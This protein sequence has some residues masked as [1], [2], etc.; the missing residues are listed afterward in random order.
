M[1]LKRLVPL[2]ALILSLTLSCGGSE[3]DPSDFSLPSTDTSSPATFPIGVDETCLSELDRIMAE[4]CQKY[5]MAPL[6][7]FASLPTGT[8]NLCGERLLQNYV[9]AFQ[10]GDFPEAVRVLER[11]ME[12]LRVVSKNTVRAVEFALAAQMKA[13][14]S[15]PDLA[16]EKSS[17][18]KAIINPAIM[19]AD[20]LL[21]TRISLVQ[22]LVHWNAAATFE[23][24]SG[25]PIG[26]GLFCYDER[27]GNL[28]ELGP[29]FRTNTGFPVIETAVSGMLQALADPRRLGLGLCSCVELGLNNFICEARIPC[30][31]GGEPTGGVAGG[32]IPGDFPSS[33]PD[34][35]TPIPLGDEASVP[36]DSSDFGDFFGTPGSDSF[37]DSFGSLFGSS[38]WP[39]L[40]EINNFVCGVRNGN[41]GDGGGG[42]PFIGTCEMQPFQALIASETNPTDRL[43]QCLRNLPPESPSPGVG[44]FDDGRIGNLADPNCALFSSSADT[45]LRRECNE[46]S[47][48]F[49]TDYE[50]AVDEA[51]N[52]IFTEDERNWLRE[53]C[54]VAQNRACEDAD[55]ISA[56][57]GASQGINNATFSDTYCD[58]HGGDRGQA[59]ESG[60]VVIA[61]SCNGQPLG[62]QEIAATVLHEARHVALFQLGIPARGA[63]GSLDPGGG[64]HHAEIYQHEIDQCLARGDMFTSQ[65]CADAQV[66][67]CRANS[68]A[69]SCAEMRETCQAGYDPLWCPGMNED[70]HQHPNTPGC[71]TPE[72]CGQNP[73]PAGCP[74]PEQCQGENPPPQC[75]PAPGGTGPNQMPDPEGG[76]LDR[77]SA[78]AERFRA[79][80][81]CT[82]GEPIEGGPQIPP[83]VR[84]ECPIEGPCEGASA[85]PLPCLGDQM[86]PRDPEPIDCDPFGDF[87][88]CGMFGSPGS[89]AG[90][91]CNE[92]DCPEGCEPRTDCS[93]CVCE[94]DG[95]FE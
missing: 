23:A 5:D 57:I 14:L 58:T 22:R 86:S 46:I 53:K 92:L 93:A 42:F 72:Q 68:S 64:G 37:T 19:V 11:I 79:V 54:T 10:A 25:Y 70:C 15:R 18:M 2:A 12:Y 90:P 17:C 24:A 62:R 89:P 67:Y 29:R 38:G 94:G 32:L 33:L 83:E 73:R 69:T 4:I 85:D 35:F 43:V 21:Y 8:I 59:S 55:I 52:N 66:G 87:G 75:P 3:N 50:D 88:N 82:V 36:P 16:D 76:G 13:V 6:P 56:M 9:T 30:A 71:L 48:E 26:V 7:Q 51:K 41:Q 34:D 80:Y 47:P 81:E 95:S 49:C 44:G 63:A 27:S 40:D 20:R 84:P 91:V 39:S 65:D 61:T 74:T 60:D 31:S 77:C 1:A 45:G 78:E 28:V